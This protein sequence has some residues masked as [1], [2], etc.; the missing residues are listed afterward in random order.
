MAHDLGFGKTGQPDRAP[1][2]QSAEPGLESRG[3][4]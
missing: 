2:F 1:S 3:L 4:V